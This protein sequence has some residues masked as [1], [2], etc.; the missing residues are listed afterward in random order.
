MIQ[1]AHVLLAFLILA[2]LCDCTSP[3]DDDTVVEDIRDEIAEDTTDSTTENEQNPMEYTY[4]ALGD[5]YTI[6]ESVE[7]SKRWPVQLADK[8]SENGNRVKSPKIVATTGWTTAELLSGIERADIED[9]KFDFVSLLIGV[10]NQFRGYDFDIYEKEFVDL[11]NRSL[12]FADSDTSHV[13]VVSIP[14]WGVTPFADGRDREKIAMEIDQYND[15][16]AQVCDSFNVQYIN[17]TDISREAEED[18]SLIANDNLHP[19][20]TMYERW[21]D[22]RIYPWFEKKFN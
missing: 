19:S 13:F 22:E 3:G 17:I 14:D 7:E 12:Q 16:S 9:E 4:L 8:A 21:V 6:G 20:A 11:L 18:S 10:N 2:V 5:S 1:K 15:Y